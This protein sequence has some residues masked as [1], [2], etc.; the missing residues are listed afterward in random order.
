MGRGAVPRA[1]EKEHGV[2]Q[3]AL[4]PARSLRSHLLRLA[5]VMLLPALLLGGWLTAQLTARLKADAE[6][7][8]AAGARAGLWPLSA[9]WRRRCCC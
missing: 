4:R 9:S 8:L 3:A 6:E 2:P 7:L 1:Q 5:L